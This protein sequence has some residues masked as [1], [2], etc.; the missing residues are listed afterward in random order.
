MKINLNRS[1]HDSDSEGRRFDS[2]RVYHWRT[3]QSLCCRVLCF[4]ALLP[5][6]RFWTYF[7][8]IWFQI[9]IF[10]GYFTLCRFPFLIY[11]NSVTNVTKPIIPIY[12]EPGSWTKVSVTM[13]REVGW[14]V[15]REGTL[16]RT[17]KGYPSKGV[18]PLWEGCICI[19]LI[20]E[21]YFCI[22]KRGIPSMR[23]ARLFFVEILP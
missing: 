12:K 2:C 7:G 11:Q 4:L 6:F 16:S 18:S 17:G 10:D 8:H 14:Q 5:C 1:F 13:D 15:S 23:I 20:F 21:V 19:C 22:Y 9:A 3:L